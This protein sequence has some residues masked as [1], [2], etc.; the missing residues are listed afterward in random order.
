MTSFAKLLSHTLLQFLRGTHLPQYILQVVEPANTVTV[1]IQHTFD[2][3]SWIIETRVKRLLQTSFSPFLLTLQRLRAVLERS[4]LEIGGGITSHIRTIDHEQ[5]HLWQPPYIQHLAPLS[6]SWKASILIITITW[7][8]KTHEHGTTATD[9]IQKQ[10]SNHS[11]WPTVIDEKQRR[12]WR[13]WLVDLLH[14]WPLTFSNQSRMHPSLFCSREN[15]PNLALNNLYFSSC[16]R[17][18]HKPHS[19]N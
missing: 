15:E 4:H 6:F 14:W 7:A 2:K 19:T 12:F 13:E 9:A 1:Q 10:R 5:A 11:S 17:Q 18:Q 16:C 3:F 8:E